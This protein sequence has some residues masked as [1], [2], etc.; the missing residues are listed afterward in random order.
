MTNPTSFPT[1][2]CGSRTRVTRFFFRYVGSFFR[3]N[4]TNRRTRFL[5]FCFRS[6]TRTTTVR[7]LLPNRFR[8]KP[9]KEPR[10]K[11]GKSRKAFFLHTTSDIPNNTPRVIIHRK[12]NSRI[13]STHIFR[14][15]RIRFSEDRFRINTKV[16]MGKGIAI[17]LFIGLSRDGHHISFPKESRPQVIGAHLA[18]NVPRRFTRRIVARLTSR[19]NPTTRFNRRKRGVTQDSPKVHLMGKRPLPTHSTENGVRRRFSRDSGIMRIFRMLGITFPTQVGTKGCN[20]REVSHT[21]KGEG[22]ELVPIVP[23]EN[24][25]P[26]FLPPT[27]HT[28]E[29]SKG[30]SSPNAEQAFVSPLGAKGI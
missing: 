22:G 13:R 5:L 16:T 18:R 3:K 25:F 20:G 29:G 7:R 19:D 23:R 30:L 8:T 27:G 21:Y 14:R 26:T 15:N 17:S 24:S 10:V 9:R 6:T 12:R 1:P 2:H 11:V 4:T 28:K